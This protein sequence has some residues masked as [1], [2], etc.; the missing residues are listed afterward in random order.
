[1]RPYC[2]YTYANQRQKLNVSYFNTIIHNMFLPDLFSGLN[3]ETK[4][5]TDGN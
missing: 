1:M 3:D 4:E 2:T 5:E